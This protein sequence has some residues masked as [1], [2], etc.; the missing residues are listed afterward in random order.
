MT[1]TAWIILIVGII[2]VVGTILYFQTRTKKLKSKFGPEYDR[3]VREKGSSVRAERELEQRTRRVEKFKVHPLPEAERERLAAEWR[4][5]QARF[6]DDPRGALSGVD[7][8]IDR[9]MKSCGYPV[10]AEFSDRAADLS[11][12]HPGV[13]EHYRIA[14]DIAESD[15]RKPASTEE[16]RLAMK[17]YKALFEDLLGRPVDELTGAR[18]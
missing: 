13:V 5:T 11:V 15:T 4:E 17:H 6:V 14:H 1:A 18:R 10:G 12:D 8:L 7:H 9:A 2:A 3:L 16:L